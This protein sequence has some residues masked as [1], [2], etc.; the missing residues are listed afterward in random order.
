VNGAPVCICLLQAER[1][2]T[3][4]LRVLRAYELMAQFQT[5]AEQVIR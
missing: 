2:G 5:A 1:L 3:V 4:L